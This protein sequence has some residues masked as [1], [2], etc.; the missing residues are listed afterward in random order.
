MAARRL[1]K[2]ASEN[3]DIAEVSSRFGGLYTAEEDLDAIPIKARVDK[4]LVATITPAQFWRFDAADSSTAAS[5]G[6]VR[7]PTTG[8]GR[9][10]KLV[11]SA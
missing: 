4:M 6:N 2:L 1:G 3:A 11:L 9:W 10:K 5:S 7:V 8:T